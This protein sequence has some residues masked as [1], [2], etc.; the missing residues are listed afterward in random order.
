[1]WQ[2]IWLWGLKSAPRVNKLFLRVIK[3]QPHVEFLA[4]CLSG[5]LVSILAIVSYVHPPPIA[6]T[7]AC[8][9]TLC[10]GWHSSSSSC[11]LGRGNKS[12]DTA[13]TDEPCWWLNTPINPHT[14]HQWCHGSRLYAPS[15]CPDLLVAAVALETECT[16][17]VF[18]S[19]LICNQS[20]FQVFE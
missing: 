4:S 20:H 5:L 1:M 15:L 12:S 11:S 7:L 10:V 2:G 19:L 14:I 17:V 18:P 3:T 9:H 6:Q 8:I 16:A 13:M